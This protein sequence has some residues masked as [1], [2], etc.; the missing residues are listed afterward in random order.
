MQRSIWDDVGADV[1]META[2]SVAAKVNTSDGVGRL[3]PELPALCEV[4][5]RW[6]LHGAPGS[7]AMLKSYAGKLSHL[8]ELCH[9]SGNISPLEA[10]I[11]T[12]VRG[13]SSGEGR[14]SWARYLA[15]G[16]RKREHGQSGAEAGAAADDSGDH[17]AHR[18]DERSSQR[19][20]VEELR[21]RRFANLRDPSSHEL[22]AIF[23]SQTDQLS[24][25]M[26]SDANHFLFEIVQNAED[27][28]YRD[29]ESPSLVFRLLRRDVLCPGDRDGADG[30]ALLVQC[31]EKGFTEVDIESISGMCRSSKKKS[32]QCIGKKARLG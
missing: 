30:G 4:T 11:A 12:V 21:E 29:G 1:D 13:A 17:G 32:S 14:A 8:A 22:R 5:F 20:F 23:C 19:R 2:E 24:T 25:G 26:Y 18:L 6:P 27:N 28:Q 3:S 15:G 10:T 9:H 31:N 16:K 7:P